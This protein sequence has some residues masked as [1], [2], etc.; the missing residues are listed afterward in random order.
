MVTHFDDNH[1]KKVTLEDRLM[2]VS[3]DDDN[4]V[5]GDKSGSRMQSKSNKNLRTMAIT[6]KTERKDSLT[7]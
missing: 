6:N 3:R 1:S 4:H 5:N 7:R 2:K